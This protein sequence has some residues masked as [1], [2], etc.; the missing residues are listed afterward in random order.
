MHCGADPANTLGKHPGIARIA[1]Q[2][3]L[4]DAPPHLARRPG[5][6]DF[7]AVN[8]AIDAQMPLDSGDWIDSDSCTHD[9]I[10]RKSLNLVESR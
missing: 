10:S 8:F 4:L 2:H 6:G 1:A 5:I 3:D 9:V 7:S